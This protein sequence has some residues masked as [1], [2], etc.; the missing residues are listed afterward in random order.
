M[1][2]GSMVCSEPAQMINNNSEKKVKLT[3][4]NSVLR[5]FKYR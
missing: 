1:T 4:N 3:A 5:F 2:T